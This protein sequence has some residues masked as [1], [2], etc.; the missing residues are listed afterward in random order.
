MALDVGELVAR[1]TLDDS[2]FIQGTQRSEQQSRQATQRISSS[3]QDITRAAQRAGQAAQAVEINDQLEREARRIAQQIQEL[4]RNAQRA[5]QS[6]DDIVMNANLLSEARR[7]ADEIEQIRTA[8]RQA[9]GAMD[10]IEL[11]NR[12]QEDLRAAQNELDDLYRQAG[13]GGG[14]AGEQGGS[15]FLSGFSD[16]I[17]NLG[18]KAGPIAGSLIGVAAIG[19]AAGAALAGAI[20][21]GMEAELQRDLF[22][23]QTGVTTAQARKFAQ[24]AGEAY[25]N[26]F[27]ESVEQNLDTARMALSTGLLDPGA[28]QRD[29]EAMIQSLDGVSTILGEEIPAVSRAASQAI[30]TGFAQDANDA[31]DLLV[32]GSQMGLNVS[33]DWLDT[34]T[35][36]GTQF[37]QLGL[38]GAEAMGLMGQAVAAGARDTDTAA[39]ALKEFAIRAID[40]STASQEGYEALGLSASEMSEQIAKGGEDARNGLELVLTKLREIED[41]VERNAAAV[42]LFGT[43]AEDL[44][45]AMYAMDLTTAVE[46]LNDYEGAAKRAI[47]VMGGNASTSVEGA[48]RAISLA[49]DGLKA[50]LAEAFGPYIQQFADTISNN[51]AGV[52]QFFI[53]IGNTAFDAAEKVLQFVSGGMRGLGEFA[54]AGSQMAASFLESI[55][56]MVAGLD[57]FM[58]PF[59][60]LI[61]GMPDFG[62]MAGD[63]AKFADTARSGG[64][65]I[66]EAMNAGADAIDTKLIPALESGQI[67]FNEFAGDMKLSAAF[68]DEIQKVNNSISSF[69]VTAD[70]TQLKI[71]NWT[72][73]L[74]QA[75]WAHKQMHDTLTAMPAAFEAQNR[76]GLEAGATVEELTRQYAANRDQLIQQAM[77]MGL[78]NKEAV[79]LINS[80]GLVPNLVQ[81]QISQPGM[82]EAHYALD[83]LQTKVIDVPDS[84][85][86]HTEALTQDSMDK[87][88]ALGLKVET[89]PDG[90]VLVTADTDD[91]QSAIDNFIARNNGKSVDM[92]VEIQ[93][94]RR[95]GGVADDF[96]GPSIYDAG[97]AD[98]GVRQRANGSLDQAHI[99]P[100]RGNGTLATT[101]LG[102]VRYAEGETGW[103]AYIP[104]A[105]S[106]RARSERILAETAKRMGFGLLKLDDILHMADGGIN[107]G[108]FDSQAAVAKAMAHDGQP[109]IYGGLDCSGY[110]SAVFNAGTGQSVR[111]TTDSD[112]EG[113]GWVPGFDP[114]GF[115]IGTN[116]G[117]G[118][119]G[120]MS[121]Y[122]YGTNIESDG[123]NGIQYGRGADSPLDFPYVYHWPGASAAGNPPREE[124]ERFGEQDLID[125]LNGNKKPRVKGS[126]STGV[127]MSTDG[128]RVFVTNWP[129][130]LG[131]KAAEKPAEERQPIWSASIRAFDQ[132]GFRDAHIAADG[133]DLIRYAE[134]GTGG[135]AYI[136]LAPA[137]RGRSV[138]LTR[139]VAHRFGFELVPMENGGLTGFGGYIGD[140]GSTFDVPLTAEGWAAM[141]PNKRRATMYNLAA[142]G[143]GGA[144][145]I[146]SGFDENGAFTG[147]FD[148]GANSHPG[149]EKAFGAWA[150]QINEQLE[151]IKKAA[152][153]PDPLQ[154]Q[155]DIDSGSRTAQIEITKR[156]L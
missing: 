77:Q 127:A 12:L 30:K 109:Y 84:K 62:D 34:I 122:L 24:A 115:S 118:T 46:Q 67:R 149:L 102:P 94:R 53:D 42:A 130:S 45:Q 10:D 39:D 142:L 58:G 138:G 79:T 75:N 72:G 135:E 1:L 126:T 86:I 54:E 38:T 3:F 56:G 40:G 132:G 41:P 112:F 61:P 87:L 105:P 35:E 44:G 82:P 21:D 81:T 8:A 50:S 55:A 20:K 117:S 98:G 92:Y 145:A 106:K 137:K 104:G 16:A 140:K 83:V 70:G 111:F 153:N 123:S 73:S 110:L 5:D 49:A 124:I 129:D 128:Q 146:A 19:L 89:L 71:Q 33:E 68:N 101:P 51:R 114:D 76:T 59:D 43:K 48:M 116:K 36:Y 131:G 100:G 18:S 6:V 143:I 74:D 9:A 23:A 156:G 95:A 152:E 88:A 2:R 108:G 93:A 37:R 64:T 119:N 25:A 65:S 4:E 32:K 154:V 27:G 151:A 99:A 107:E 13:Q 121:G 113:M 155:V 28:T 80:Y 96:V 148:T 85:T 14:P 133:A 125:D 139:E 147:Q 26:V 15:N 22:Q 120:H 78:T 144:F 57:A 7:A 69:G 29:A 136:P 90:T 31:F 141:S 97:M 63:I 103:E 134:K 150:D 17:G 91:G 47:D 52:I 66:S 60:E 11:G